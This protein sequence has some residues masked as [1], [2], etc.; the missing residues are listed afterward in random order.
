MATNSLVIQDILNLDVHAI[1]AA[2][3]PT[4][5]IWH[6][7]HAIP[8]YVSLASAGVLLIRVLIA[9]KLSEVAFSRAELAKT[10]EVA[11]ESVTTSHVDAHGGRIIFAA[12]ALTFVGC[13]ELLRVS[14]DRFSTLEGAETRVLGFVSLVFAYTSLL[15]LFVIINPRPT[16]VSHHITLVLA[17]SWTAFFIYD[18]MPLMTYTKSPADP[19]YKLWELVGTLSFTAILLPLVTPRRYKPFNP[20]D[21][22]PPNPV[23]TASPL[24]LSLFSFLDGTVWKAY[25]VPHL[26]LS[27]LPPLAD[28]D[29]SKNLVRDAFPYL[30]PYAEGDAGTKHNSTRKKSSGI[31]FA[32]LGVFRRE[33]IVATLLLLLNNVV[34]LFSPYG[35]KRLLEHIESEGRG[36]TVKPWV[37][38]ASL[39]FAPFASTLITQQYKRILARSTVR[40]EATFTQLMLQHA[41]RIRVVAEGKSDPPR[42]AVSSPAP[43]STTASGSS[44]PAATDNTGPAAPGAVPLESHMETASETAATSSTSDKGASLV[45]RMN[46]L[47]STDLQAISQGAEFIQV[48]FT[49]PLLIILTLGF[50]YTILGWSALAGFAVLVALSPLPA[51]FSWLLQ[52]AAKEVSKKGDDRV[53]AVTE[54]MSVI[55]MIK[56][57]GWENRMSERINEKREIE[58]LWVWWNKI[59]TLLTM[60]F[61][62]VIPAVTMAATFSFYALL[63]KQPLDAATVFSTYA[64]FGILSGR[65]Y[66]FFIWVPM[67]IKA[68][69]SLGR[70]NDFLQNSELLDDFTTN[71]EAIVQYEPSANEIGLRAATFSWSN[72]E[73]DA[74]EAPTPSKR[75][76]RL[77][78]DE[79]LLFQP[80]CINLII[81][82]TGSGKTSLLMALLGEMHFLPSG[83]GSWFNFPRGGGV[84]YAAQES[85]IM[86]TTIKENILFGTPFDEERYNKV[87]YQCA[88]TRDLELFQAGDHTEVG[89][90]G[91]TLSGGQKARITLARAVYSSA[92]IVLLDDVLAALDVHTA[93]W[94]VDKC[95][96]GDLI[97]GRTVLLVTHNV[98]MAAPISDFVVSLDSDGRISSQGTIS[99]ALA[100]NSKL[101]LEVVEDQ[102]MKLKEEDEI[103]G[104][105]EADVRKEVEG[106]LIIEEEVSE[107]HIGWESIKMYLVALGGRRWGFFWFVFSTA[108]FFECA[109]ENVQPWLLGVWATEYSLHPPEEVN[110]SFYLTTYVGL[111]VL[112]LVVFFCAQM[113]LALGSL[114]ASESLHRRLIKSILGTTLRWPDKTPTSRV[115]TRVTQDV[116]A[117]DTTIPDHFSNLFEIAMVITVRFFAILYFV[118]TAGLLGLLIAFFG[119]TM[120][121]IYMKSQLSVKREMSKAKAP[122]MAHFGASI[123]GITSIRAYGAQKSILSKSMINVDKHT[124]AS[125]VFNDLTCWMGIRVDALGGLFA[126][127]LG[128]YFVYGPKSGITTSN[129]AFTL[130]NAVLFGQLVLMFVRIFNMFEVSGNSLERLLEYMNIEQEAKANESGLPPAHWPSSGSLRVE[131]LSARYSS[132]GPNVLHDVSFATTAGERIGIVGRTGSGKSSLTLSLLRCIPTEGEVFYDGVLTSSINLDALR[133]QITIIPQVPELLSGTLRRNLDPFDQFDDATLNAALRDAGLFSLQMEGEEGRITLDSTMARGGSNLSVGQRQIIA[134]ARAMVRESKLLILDEATSAIDYKTDAVIQESLRTQLK[135][136]VTVITIAHRLQTIMDADR[137]MVLDAGRIVEFD[138]PSE[139]LKKEDGFLRSLVD[140]SGDKEALYTAAR[141]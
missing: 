68:R 81:G 98:N 44:T 103:E 57:F 2:T 41:L 137:I 29:H 43:L 4:G 50:L 20:S 17:A 40:L 112:M 71:D 138:R 79:E 7:L 87:I 10:R 83:P 136:D 13:L 6:S 111:V 78:I 127:S 38:V 45:G 80:G 64:L 96:V 86:N 140:E 26:P 8:V 37:W 47:I 82:P 135:N 124:R 66:M 128:W 89:E 5:D 35:L 15:A 22:L 95:F 121:N 123:E 12:E 33:F 117:V 3:S 51:S 76:F 92:E 72:E 115:I 97:K 24:S 77:H 105:Q 102:E 54:T 91:L 23:Q 133:S 30:D 126:A 85:W 11:P 104:G 122:V 46:N 100:K 130:S 14:L 27:E 113:T 53:E 107:G 25:Q 69:V 88:L 116:A 19:E 134:L 9:S 61:H 60:N 99:D 67:V 36:A 120:G 118:P 49:G 101:K 119:G 75:R 94:V 93:K 16:S 56:M 39:F 28:S 132:D 108:T 73:S 34:T 114:R 59:Y 74:L 18:V 129:Q 63:M 139:L 65:M 141:V 42:I 1:S 32:V 62:F 21:P 48:F 90:K 125:R 55:R 131:R 52:G 109:I 110:V 84:A 70:L 31:V 106:K 58:L